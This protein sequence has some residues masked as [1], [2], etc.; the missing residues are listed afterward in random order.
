[1]AYK[2]SQQPIETQPLSGQSADGQLLGTLCRSG[3]PTSGTFEVTDTDGRQSWAP[4]DFE[5]TVD[6]S[7]PDAPVLVSPADGS[8]GVATSPALSAHRQRSRRR[9]AHRQRRAAAGGAPEFTIIALPDTQHYSEAFP[10][11][12]TSQTQWI[13]DNKDARNIVFVTHEGDIVEHNNLVVGV[14]GRRTTSMSL[15]DGVVP[16]GMGPGNH[17]QPTTLYNQFFPYTRYQG[18]PWYGGHYQ[19][20]ND[21]NYQLFSGGGMDFVIVHLEFCP[22]AGARVVGQFGPPVATPIASA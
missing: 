8:T 9:T 4:S 6:A 12:F 15:L 10:A 5:L 1:M 20:L 16:Y 3:R 17:D 21:N 19:N 11:I 13:V 2:S 7:A 22:P 14:A 18:Q